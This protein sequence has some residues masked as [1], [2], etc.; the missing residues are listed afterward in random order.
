MKIL[1]LVG[2]D[3]EILSS[4]VES[5]TTSKVMVETFQGKKSLSGMINNYIFGILLFCVKE[6]S[7]RNLISGKVEVAA[8]YSSVLESLVKLEKN[9]VP[10]E[11]EESRIFLASIFF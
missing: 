5:Y 8:F 2:N 7:N 11:N 4:N 1:K 9:L 10:N 6:T 3:L